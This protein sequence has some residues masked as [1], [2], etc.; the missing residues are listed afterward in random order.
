VALPMAE[1]LKVMGL[2]VTKSSPTNLW[3]AIDKD[4]RLE[5]FDLA[6]H[7][8]VRLR[9][10]TL[11]EM[12]EAAEVKPTAL[13]APISND[14]GN[15]K[16]G[17]RVVH[18]NHGPGV[19]VDRNDLTV[20][21][22]FDSQ[23]PSAEP[24]QMDTRFCKDSL[25]LETDPTTTPAIGD[26]PE[27]GRPITEEERQANFHANLVLHAEQ[28]KELARMHAAE[29]ATEVEQSETL[30]ATRKRIEDLEARTMKH[31]AAM[32]TLEMACQREIGFDVGP[33]E[34]STTQAPVAA[35]PDGFHPLPADQV[36]GLAAAKLNL[37]TLH[38][39]IVE[40]FTPGKKSKNVG[41]LALEVNGGVFLVRQ[42]SPDRTRW[43]LQQLVDLGVWG[44]QFEEVHGRPVAN[45]DENA[46]GRI[47]RAGGG[48]DCG[49]LVKIG[50]KQL[51]LAPESQGL[52]VV[53]TQEAVETYLRSVAKPEADARSKAA[54]DTPEPDES[55]EDDAGE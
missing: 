22:R 48:A 17:D 11:G 16:K 5:V 45:W 7:R 10:K 14:I 53:A 2:K 12:V 41:K 6:G 42:H 44:E 1:A 31:A 50:R 55:S 13:A 36:L 54:G 35:G 3:D 30:K 40:E 29:K 19:V 9:V 25:R 8:H 28:G 51:V 23:E 4:G 18:T 37:A 43:F 52:V 21:V 49:R 46:E 24:H 26:V 15:A 20:W 47:S 32:P 27:V 39:H 34:G 33:A 38:Q